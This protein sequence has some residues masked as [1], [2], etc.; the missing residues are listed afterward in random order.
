MIRPLYHSR[1]QSEKIIH[2]IKPAG[3]ETFGV[4]AYYTIFD[5][6]RKVLSFVVY[7][8]IYRRSTVTGK[9]M[10]GKFTGGKCL[11][12]NLASEAKFWGQI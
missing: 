9:Y 7:M 12:V 6:P 2:S 3:N 4:G 1:L 8:S 10:Y 11:M 5:K